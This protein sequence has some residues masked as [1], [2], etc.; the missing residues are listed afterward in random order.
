MSQ[1]GHGDGSSRAWG[2]AWGW[3][4]NECNTY[5]HTIHVHTCIH[6]LVHTQLHVLLEGKCR[7]EKE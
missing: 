1:V 4:E 2:R 5:L 3:L 6:V 7:G